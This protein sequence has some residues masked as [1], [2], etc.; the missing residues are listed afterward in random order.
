MRN[1]RSLIAVCLLE[2]AIVAWAALP[3]AGARPGAKP[4]LIAAVCCAV[5]GLAK[6]AA[7]STAVRATA[8]Q[9]RGLPEGKLFL[10]APERMWQQAASALIAVPWPQ[11]LIVAVIGLEAL[12]PP[13]PWHTAVLG[14]V[15]LGYLAALQTAESGARL[16]MFAV[17]LPL[18]AAGIGLAAISVAAAALPASSTGS[19]SG[20][21]AVLAAV[22]AILAAALALPV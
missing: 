17:Q 21:L 4:T 19:G 18:I 6:L 15:L 13:A 9:D 2:A 12:H 22:A 3:A 11:L 16:A 8:D 1:A 20:W 14:L 7:S 5:F 10:S